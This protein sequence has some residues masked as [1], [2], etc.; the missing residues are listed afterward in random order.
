MFEYII[1]NKKVYIIFLYN[2]LK[3]F[4]KHFFIA[5]INLLFFINF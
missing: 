5:A 2:F 1:V 4:L 3:H